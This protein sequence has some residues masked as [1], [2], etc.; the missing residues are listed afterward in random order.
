MGNMGILV[1]ANT[2][3]GVGKSTLATNIAVTRANSGRSVLLIDGDEQKTSMIFT[4]VRTE[5]L[6]ESD[7]TAVSLQGASIRTQG[8]LLSRNYE[9]VVIDVGGRDTASLR[10]ALTIA[11]IVLIPVQ[12]KSFDLWA[13][14]TM[15]E[16]ITEAKE[17]NDNLSPLV[18]LNAADPAGHDNEDTLEAIKNMPGL[19]VLQNTIG[20]RKVF[21]N[22][23]ATGRGITEYQP[24]DYKAIE[25]LNSL[26]QSLYNVKG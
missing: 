16:L 26:V 5:R 4:E 10:A 15:I 24:R 22:A 7:Y 8:R 20:R 18:V 11:D 23:S 2:K 12:P 25:E 19:H 3:G 6:G 13:L 21:S 9:D 14:D 17:I 1:V